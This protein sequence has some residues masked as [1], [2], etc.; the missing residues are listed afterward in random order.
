[1]GCILAVFALFVPRLVM[2]AIF[3]FSHWF[4]QAYA[5]VVWPVLGF[6]FMPYTTLAYMAAMLNNHHQVSGGW[7]VL[8][9][10]AVF[11]DLGGQGGY[12]SRRR[13]G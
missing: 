3:I 5:T 10:V 7:I 4:S 11:I 8:L 9:I 12:V 2:A 6:I 1:M 13:Q